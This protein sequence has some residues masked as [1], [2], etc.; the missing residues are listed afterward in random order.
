MMAMYLTTDFETTLRRYILGELPDDARLEIEQKLVT[1]PDAFEALGVVEDELTEEYLEHGLSSAERLRFEQSLLQAPH[2]R[3]LVGFFG[4]LKQRA[5]AFSRT[6]SPERR[7]HVANWFGG[8]RWQTAWVAAAAAAVLILSLAGN[9]W[10]SLR[11]SALEDSIGGLQ[12]QRE[13]EARG[14]QQVSQQL[15]GLAAANRELQGRV[16]AERR[17]RAQAET[18]AA[19]LQRDT[20]GARAPVPTF[21]LTAGLFR[22][23]GVLARIVVPAEAVVVRLRLALVGDGYPL[24][25][26]ALVDSEGDQVWSASKLKAESAGSA[27]AVFLVLPTVMLSRGDYQVRLSGMPPGGESEPIATY[28]FRV[29]AR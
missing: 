2:R 28:P 8:L 25:E 17:Q 1:D 6:T 27:A 3:R 9:V 15:G 19:E 13:R 4:T 18:R 10:L 24:Y 20:P 22:S 12:A 5:S 11:Q 14:R 26:A 21:A 16:E 23:E 7:R 29:I